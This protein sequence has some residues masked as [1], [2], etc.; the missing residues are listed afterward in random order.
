MK[1]YYQYLRVILTDGK[2]YLSD[3]AGSRLPYDIYI[4]RML[5]TK[6]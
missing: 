1:T 5:I 3:A 4:S 6:Y 2:N